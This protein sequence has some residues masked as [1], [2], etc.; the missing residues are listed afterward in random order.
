[1]RTNSVITSVQIAVGIWAVALLAPSGKA[2]DEIPAGDDPSLIAQG[3]ALFQTKICFTC[4]Q[5]D[6]AV[7]APAGEA[8]KA[9]KFIGDFW[10]KEREVQISSDP[11]SPVFTDSGKT[12][13]VKLDEAYFME[14]VEKPNAKILKGSI[15]GM[16]PLPTTLEERKALAAYVKSLS[17]TDGSGTV[18]TEQPTPKET[19][20]EAAPDPVQVAKG[21]KLFQAK[22]CFTC[23]Q[24]DPAVPS[25]AGG[26]LKAPGFMG[27][28][29]GKPRQ[30]LM[31]VGGSEATV[32]FD[33]AYFMESVE[34]PM[35][36]IAK[37]SLPG[38]APLPTTLEER[39]NL[40]A[41]V[42]SLSKEGAEQPATTTSAVPKQ[43]WPTILISIVVLLGL[44]WVGLKAGTKEVEVR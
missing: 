26:A 9:T 24:I 1:M 38:M 31:G 32:T 33:K 39:E 25:P 34:K 44:T 23:H 30:V 15:P 2:A 4:H 37:G 41:Y 6:P 16:A 14:S 21:K 20:K 3:K 27:D 40:A 10:G 36:M 18:V 11:Q 22:A 13:N 19:P 35:V 5:S 17:K 42:Q 43:Y 28:F 29:W 7:P 12:E 8:L